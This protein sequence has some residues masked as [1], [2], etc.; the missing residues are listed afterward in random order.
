MRQFHDSFSLSETQGGLS[1]TVA[2]PTRIQGT[3]SSN[4]EFNG[5]GVAETIGR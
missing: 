1:D 5:I 2:E 3:P 4:D